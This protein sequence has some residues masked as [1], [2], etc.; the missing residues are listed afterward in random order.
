MSLKIEFTDLPDIYLITIESLRADKV[1]ATLTPNINQLAMKSLVF[2]NFYCAGAPTLYSLPT[3][4]GGTYPFEY[5]NRRGLVPGIPTLPE[6]LREHGYHT[7][8]TCLGGWYSKIFGY[9]RGFDVWDEYKASITLLIKTAMEYLTKQK[10][11]VPDMNRI[12]SYMQREARNEKPLFCWYHVGRSHAPYRPDYYDFRELTSKGKLEYFYA[13]LKDEICWRK[14]WHRSRSIDKY[15][16]YLSSFQRN[17]ELVEKLY[18][19]QIKSTDR[20]LGNFFSELEYLSTLRDRNYV[21][22]VTADHGEEFMEGGGVAHSQNSHADVVAKIPLVVY[23]NWNQKHELKEEF[24]STLYIPQKILSYLNRD[25]PSEWNMPYVIEN[26]NR[27]V[28]QEGTAHYAPLIMRKELTRQEQERYIKIRSSSL[29]YTKFLESNV[30]V[31][32]PKSPN[33]DIPLEDS[34]KIV[35]NHLQRQERNRTKRKIN[36]LKKEKVGF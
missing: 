36:L 14:Y 10:T 5:T 20:N 16:A 12:H 27:Y 28:I 6:I 11:S 3:I 29:S 23:E 9:T 33:A 32:E 24:Q 19:A 13:L 35:V 34:E 8:T 25:V 22:I 17:I 2:E 7:C 26:E 30:S 15:M 18:D 21:V 31:L 1:S 4:I